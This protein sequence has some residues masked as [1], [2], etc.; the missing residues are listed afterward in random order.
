MPVL[1]YSEINPTQLQSLQARYGL[2]IKIVSTNDAIPGSFWK[3][4]EAGLIGNQ[5]YISNDTPVHSALHE[6]CHYICM[7]APRRK[8][9]HTDAGG[10]T[11][12]EAAVCYLQV[13][14]AD[15]IPEMGRARSFSDMDA[16]G[17]SYR[18]GSAQAWFE[19]DAE[20]ALAWL[21]QHRLINSDQQP[22]FLLRQ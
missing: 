12:E 18:L 1:L 8:A 14:L 15:L 4:P 10:T 3:A 13:L 9:L 2:E 17:Y 21:V 6:T 22:C 20:D 19:Q 5:L 7:D 11:I 16:W